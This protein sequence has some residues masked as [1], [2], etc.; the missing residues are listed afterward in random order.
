MATLR[1]KPYVW[2]TWL[3]P[4]L[5]GEAQCQFATWFKAHHQYTKRVDDTFDLAKWS[6]DH[7]A[8]LERRAREL[9]DDGWQVLL[10]NSNAFRL[11][12]KSATLAGK[13]DIVARRDGD[14]L[15]VDAKTG[16]PKNR[17][18]WQVLIYL[19]VLPKCF[20]VQ[21]D[22]LRGEVCYPSHRTPVVGAELTQDRADRIWALIRKVGD[23]QRLA[24]V[25][26]ANECH[27]CDITAADCPQRVEEAIASA[28]VSE[29]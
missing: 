15:V 9:E 13:P 14:T 25:P 6:A 5:A 16:Q 8:L 1:T 19:A 22:R 28:L 10:E 24:C 12:G 20:A 3:T 7:T 4:I 23:G 2:V 18:W 26:S 17:D 27:F 29:F 11:H 21:T